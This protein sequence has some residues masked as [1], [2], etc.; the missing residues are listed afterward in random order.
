[1][2]ATIH[3]LRHTFAVHRLKQG[4]NIK[5]IQQLLGHSSIASTEI[6]LQ[7]DDSHIAEVAR[8]TEVQY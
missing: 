2:S 5:E 3:S 8:R 6:Y 4:A 7:L 1:M